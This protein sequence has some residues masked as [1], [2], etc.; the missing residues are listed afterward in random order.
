MRECVF[1]A[2]RI[3]AFSARTVSSCFSLSLATDFLYSSSAFLRAACNTPLS[4]GALSLLVSPAVSVVD[5]CSALLL[6]EAYSSSSSLIRSSIPETKVSCF[7]RI[8]SLVI[9][10]ACFVYREWPSE[11][12]NPSL[13]MLLILI[14]MESFRNGVSARFRI[15]DAK[16]RGPIP[17]KKVEMVREGKGTVL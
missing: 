3:S 4:M 5:F 14:T 15:C 17:T 9:S 16:Y 2:S 7:R 13:S 10:T 12:L 8:S 1:L 11:I 6:A